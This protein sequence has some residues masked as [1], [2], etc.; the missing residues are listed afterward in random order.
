MLKKKIWIFIGVIGAI[1]MVSGCKKEPTKEEVE[2][3][4]YYID[5]LS[6]YNKIKKEKKTL[7]DKLT[8]ATAET[9]EDK[10]T[11]ALLDKILRDSLVKMEIA[12]G[13]EG[14][15]SFFTENKGILKLAKQLAEKVDVVEN[16]TP[17]DIRLEHIHQYTYTLY[18]EDNSVFEL[19]I[20]DGNYVIFKDLPTRVFYVYKANRFGRAFLERTV[21]YPSQSTLAKMI[22]TPFVI[23]GKKVY[24][25]DVAYQL[26]SIIHEVDKT[27]VNKKKIKKPIKDDYHFYYYGEK[28]TLGLGEKTIK[29]KD[30]KG[31]SYYKVGKEVVQQLR[32]IV[33]P[34]KVKSQG[35]EKKTETNEG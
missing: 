3:S 35:V 9:P 5:L 10:E 27:K 33:E 4:K 22:E 25:N 30:R 26:T 12:Y 16:L 7:A 8:E 32:K 20:Y 15:N 23:K 29:V 11:K 6:Q 34:E 24:E 19:E 21:D 18:D 28:I 13:I 1:S 31:T 14:E 17:E 2:Q